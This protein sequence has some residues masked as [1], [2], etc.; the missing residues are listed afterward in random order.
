[1]TTADARHLLR[2]LG[3]LDRFLTETLDP[4]LRTTGI[5][6]EHWQVLRLLEDGQGH[7]MGEI[8][9]SA[10][11]PGATATRVV[12]LL[13]ANMLIYRRNDPLDRRR[14]LV[15]LSDVGAETL[16]RIQDGLRDH[17]SPALTGFSAS[18]RGKLVELLDRFLHVDAS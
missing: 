4:I 9:Q 12:D 6:R 5:G 8:A 11:L 14:V 2:I 1:M 13:A 17:T 15:H 16:R 10:G 7:A 18:D 3:D